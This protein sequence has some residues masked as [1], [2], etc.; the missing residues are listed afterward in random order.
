MG[1]RVLLSAF[2]LGNLPRKKGLPHKMYIGVA[3]YLLCHLNRKEYGCKG[4]LCTH[5]FG[6]NV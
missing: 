3:Y 5:S 1:H 2:S 6:D 4:F